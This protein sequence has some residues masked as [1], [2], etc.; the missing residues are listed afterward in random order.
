[1]G[2][3]H[4]RKYKQNFAYNTGVSQASKLDICVSIVLLL[5]EST[6]KDLSSK[7]RAD[8]FSGK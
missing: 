6:N 1:M 8:Q 7:L 4:P 2:F 5:N 3:S